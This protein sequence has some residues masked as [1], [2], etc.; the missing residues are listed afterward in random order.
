LQIRDR[1]LAAYWFSSPIS[2]RD[3]MNDAD[4]GPEVGPAV[5]PPPLGSLIL[6]PG[7]SLVRRS[8]ESLPDPYLRVWVAMSQWVPSARPAAMPA[9]GGTAGRKSEG[10]N[11]TMGWAAVVDELRAEFPGAIADEIRRPRN[12]R[13]GVPVPEQSSPGKE[14]SGRKSECQDTTLTAIT[15]S[16]ASPAEATAR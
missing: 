15:A 7:I 8:T 5:F 2:L 3:L 16:S 6:A 1:P 13:R 11:V 12:S 10:I 14:V 9:S 4:G